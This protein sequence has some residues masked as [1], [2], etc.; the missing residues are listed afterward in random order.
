MTENPESP[1]PVT[2]WVNAVIWLAAAAAGAYAWFITSSGA[3]AFLALSFLLRVPVAFNHPMT[4]A[5]FNQP[6]ARR[7]RPREGFPP[8]DA[9]LSIVGFVL[10]LVGLGLLS[11]NDLWPKVKE[12]L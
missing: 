2:A 11:I 4:L 5:A 3:Y 6:F 12:W 8:G 10:F 1:S 9:L 7:T